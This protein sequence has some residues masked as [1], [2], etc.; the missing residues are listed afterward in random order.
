[1]L[2]RTQ[3]LLFDNLRFA[4][5]DDWIED[6]LTQ[7]PHLDVPHRDRRTEPHQQVPAYDGELHTSTCLDCGLPLDLCI[8]IQ[9]PL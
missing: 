9:R 3:L 1:M 8:G 5:A 6:T 7:H 4:P 2:I